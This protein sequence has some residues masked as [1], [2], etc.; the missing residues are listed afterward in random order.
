MKVATWSSSRRTSGPTSSLRSNNLCLIVTCAERF[1]PLQE[2]Y[3]EKPTKKLVNGC[4]EIRALMICRQHWLKDLT[5]VG[6]QQCS[7]THTNQ[8]S[9]QRTCYTY[10]LRTALTF[11]GLKKPLKI[12][13]SLPWGW[14]LARNFL[15][16]FQRGGLK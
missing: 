8:V 15:P 4:V 16:N 12:N 11:A 6:G 2:L 1:G 5:T 10:N 13:L 7:D 14:F 3:Q 9:Q